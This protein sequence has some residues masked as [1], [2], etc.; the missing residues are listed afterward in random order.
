[1]RSEKPFAEKPLAK[2]ALPVWR[3]LWKRHGDRIK[4]RCPEVFPAFVAN[5]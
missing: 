3:V 5:K 1:M 4:D 2:K